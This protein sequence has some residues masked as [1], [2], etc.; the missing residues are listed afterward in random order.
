MTGEYI[1]TSG[2]TESLLGGGGQR[3]RPDLH[4]GAGDLED[5]IAMI[6]F[7]ITFIVKCQM[8]GGGGRMVGP[9]CEWG[10]GGTDSD[11]CD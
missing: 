10:R 7:P 8:G 5:G 9:W 4:L 3:G 11:L 1:Q 2:V 6:F